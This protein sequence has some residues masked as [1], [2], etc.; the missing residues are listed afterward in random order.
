M[1]T[2][3]WAH[4]TDEFKQFNVIANPESAFN[5]VWLLKEAAQLQTDGSRPVRIQVRNLDGH[6]VP[7][8]CGFDEFCSYAS[9]R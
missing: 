6:L 9:G 2:V 1:L 7:L 4:A 8:S 3:S 5:L